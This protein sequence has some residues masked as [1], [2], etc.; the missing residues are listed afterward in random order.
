VDLGLGYWGPVIVTSALLLGA[1]IALILLLIN[2]KAIKGKPSEEKGKIFAS[3]EELKSGE[4]GA[5]S[6][7]F[8]SP[9]RRVFG[10]FYKYIAPAHSGVLNTYLLWV[11]IGFGVILVSIWLLLR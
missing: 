8:Y 10:S 7:Q 1:A 9:L 11:V 6:E 4:S 2:R 5:D 3:G